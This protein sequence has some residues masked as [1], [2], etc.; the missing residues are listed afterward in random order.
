M[1]E[2]QS[3]IKQCDERFRTML[4]SG[5]ISLIYYSPRGQEV[6]PAAVVP[7]LRAD[8]HLVTTYRGLHDHLAKGV[9]LRDLWA[10]FLGRST[11]TCKGKGGPMHIT[12]PASGVMVTTGIVGAGLPIANGL[13]LAS[14][15][16]GTDQVTV[17]SFG[18]GASN[19]G[20]FHEALNLASVWA[21]PVVF[22]CH[23]NQYAE[24]TPLAEGTSVAR[25][26]DRAVSYSMPGVTVDGNDPI[27]MW[28]AAGEA[29]ARAR[30]GGGPTLL[31][32]VTY[33]FWGH[34]L[35]DAMEYMPTEERAAAMEADPVPRYRAW[36]VAEGHAS[37]EE[38][39]DIEARAATA[40]DDAVEFAL[41]SPPPDASE[42][43]T[44][45]FAEV[46]R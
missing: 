10:E 25:I 8:D 21:L 3:T 38:L 32:A 37:E 7:H 9:P 31:E 30:S 40:I 41:A 17:V 26:A 23:N 42:L 1:F 20:A 4:M 33:R 12:H 2:I 15:L 19:I 45:V 27:A 28:R 6:I 29:V 34:L 14:Q 5:Q 44:D 11:G 39:L 35:G 22:V 46:A 16:R 24:H 43:F 13:A 18:D 36:L